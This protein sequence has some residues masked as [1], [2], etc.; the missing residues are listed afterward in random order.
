MNK[1]EQAIKKL[2]EQLALL[3]EANRIHK[4]ERGTHITE[5]PD[6]KD[7]IDNEDIQYFN[8]KLMKARLK[9]SD[10]KI[11]DSLNPLIVDTSHREANV[12]EP[13]KEIDWKDVKEKD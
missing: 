6:D 8:N 2:E 5:L 13:D 12:I 7:L 10:V 1:T 11:S 4:L 9:L 3:I